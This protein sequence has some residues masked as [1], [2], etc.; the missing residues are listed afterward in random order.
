MAYVSSYYEAMYS[1]ENNWF[2]NKKIYDKGMSFSQKENIHSN[3]YKYVY[4]IHWALG[5][6]S[7]I[8]LLY[9]PGFYTIGLLLILMFAILKRDKRLLPVVFFVVSIILTCIY[10]PIVN[11]FRY[12]YAYMMII[13]LLLPLVFLKN[14]E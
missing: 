8:G 9:R 7:V 12:S 4:E 11:Y 2:G 3:L 5:D 13:P 6:S 1:R 10:S 14:S